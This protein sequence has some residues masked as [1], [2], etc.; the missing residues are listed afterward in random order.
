M[1]Q[2]EIHEVSSCEP[3]SCCQP[4]W[5]DLHF[6]GAM[7]L[8]SAALCLES[9]EH[10]IVGL[11]PCN[12]HEANVGG[13]ASKVPSSI[14]IIISTATPAVLQGKHLGMQQSTFLR[15]S[16]CTVCVELGP[17]YIARAVHK[18]TAWDRRG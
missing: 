6:I 18:Y 15:T 16:A 8:R 5:L 4:R 9:C 3:T 1:W 12:F 7:T 2:I 10:V 17:E 13:E 11:S 14:K